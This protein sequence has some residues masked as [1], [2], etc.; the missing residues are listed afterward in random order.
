MHTR[1]YISR[2]LLCLFVGPVCLAN[3]Q[4]RT[5]PRYVLRPG[6]TLQLQYH[7]LPELN[8]TVI[9]Q[10]DGFVSINLAGD[11]HVSGMTVQQVHDVI[12]Q[13]E[14]SELNK[15]ELNLSLEEFTRPY[16]VVAGEVGKPGQIE[17]RD[18]VS[19]LSAILMAGGFSA[20]AKTG[21]VIVFRRV[22]DNLAEVKQLNL[23]HLGKTADL[24]HD[25]PLQAGDIVLVPRDRISKLQ[26]FIQA[27]NIGAYINPL[28]GLP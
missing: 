16:V 15:P 1:K 26:H 11:L 5:R 3:A 19:A 22:N 21:Q 13:K 12:V 17:I 20:N 10:P 27:V 2:L 9:V 24:E 25:L 8:Q 4:L 28:Q 18:N 7:L 23:R 14:S 6:D